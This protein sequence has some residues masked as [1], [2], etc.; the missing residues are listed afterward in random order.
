MTTEII[1]EV[2][3][4]I[5]KKM[6]AEG[7]KVLFFLDNAPSHLD[8][9]Q[10]GLRNIKL[11]FFPKNTKSSLQPCDAGIIKTFKHRYK[12]LLIRYIV[13]RIDKGNRS[14]SEITKDVTIL[15]VIKSIQTSWAE[16]SENT[17][18]NRFLKWGFDE[19]DVV[20]DVTVDHEFDELLQELCSDTT[21][22]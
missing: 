10:E 2:L 21:V 3:R 11:D 16:V 18:K 4:M 19:P 22:E 15:K 1:Q 7:R 8:I 20:A 14:A 6:I 5:D 9:L 13:A 12:K 17:I